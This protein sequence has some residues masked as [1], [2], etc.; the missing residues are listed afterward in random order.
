MLLPSPVLVCTSLWVSSMSMV[1]GFGVALS[2]GFDAGLL[3]DKSRE[4]VAGRVQLG[5]CR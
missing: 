4:V 5:S 2:C 1:G 3:I